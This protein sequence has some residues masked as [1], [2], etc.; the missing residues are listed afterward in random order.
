MPITFKAP[1]KEVNNLPPLTSSKLL[2]LAPGAGGGVNITTQVSSHCGGR[3]GVVKT[4]TPS[5]SGGLLIHL[6]MA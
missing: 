5:A 2:F 4:K 3:M 1:G 6:T